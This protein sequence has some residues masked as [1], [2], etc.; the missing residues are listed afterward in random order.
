MK[1][2]IYLTKI[3]TARTRARM[4]LGYFFNLLVALSHDVFICLI[5]TIT[6]SAL[7]IIAPF[8]L[9][10]MAIIPL[11]IKEANLLQYYFSLKACQIELFS[12]THAVVDYQI[13]SHRVV[14]CY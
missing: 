11:A 4:Y 5:M 14:K 6:I 8:H 10:I 12:G 3:D 2:H 13:Q 1:V 9:A 7:R